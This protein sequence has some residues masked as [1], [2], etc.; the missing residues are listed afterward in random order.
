MYKKELMRKLLLA[1][2]LFGQNMWHEAAILGNLKVLEVLRSGAKE[3][4]INTEEFLQDQNEFGKLTSN[5][6]R[7]TK[8]YKHQ[9]NCGS[10]LK[11][12]KLFI[13]V[14]SIH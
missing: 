12:G 10:G 7:R 2:D 5:L 1:K 14:Y 3:A 6:R 13:L 8:N 11:K 9:R 4:E